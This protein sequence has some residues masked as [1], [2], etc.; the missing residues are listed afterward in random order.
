MRHRVGAHGTAEHQQD[1][2]EDCGLDHRQRD[3][4][5]D[6]PLGRIENGRRLL[7]VRVHVPEDA[8]DED[9]R[10]RRIVQTEHHQA[11]EQALTEPL[12]HVDLEQRGQQSVGGAGDLGAPEQVLPHHRQRP[13]GH[14][15]GEDEDGAQILAKRHIGAGDE[16]REG[17][18]VENGNDAGAHGKVYRVDQR[19]PQIRL[20]ELAGKEVGVV[21]DRPAGGLTRQMRVNGAGV[22]LERILH[23]GDN[24][25]DGG[26]CQD[27]AQHQQDDIVRLGE[28]GLY[29]VPPD[30]RRTDREGRGLTHVVFSFLS[31]I[32]QAPP[33][34]G[35][36]PEAPFT[37][38]TTVSAI[39]CN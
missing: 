5:H 6:A 7:K 11:G 29:L 36:H 39:S 21:D 16:E 10:K 2:G 24:G 8:A 32:E 17:A 37:V 1:R 22:D 27:N 38:Y 25:R 31:G 12:G 26:D 28:K 23:N 4:E 33:D 13:L 18:A 9:V 20:G 35:P 34:A 3:A 15:V 19:R 30:R 14:D